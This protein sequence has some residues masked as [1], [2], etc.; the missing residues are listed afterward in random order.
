[1]EPGH[2]TSG[3]ARRLYWGPGRAPAGWIRLAGPDGAAPDLTCNI[4][5]DGLP[6]DSESIVATIR[7]KE[8]GAAFA[9]KV[10]SRLPPGAIDTLRPATAT[11]APETF[12]AQVQTPIPMKRFVVGRDTVRVKVRP[13]L[14]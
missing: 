10:A 13:I 2:Q 11:D 6:F 8:N 1:M 14:R 4:V 3:T 12:V 5:H 9:G 7:L